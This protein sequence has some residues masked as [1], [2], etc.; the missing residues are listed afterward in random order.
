MIVKDA[1]QKAN[2]HNFVITYTECID[3]AKSITI[4]ASLITID[5]KVSISMVFDPIAR[6]WY[7]LDEPT[8]LEFCFD[9]IMEQEIQN[10]N[11]VISDGKIISRVD[12]SV[13][14]N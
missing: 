12:D 5:K 14:K 10:A 3:E 13:S 7:E 1:L 8:R 2:K 11:V 4:M 6:N 9:L